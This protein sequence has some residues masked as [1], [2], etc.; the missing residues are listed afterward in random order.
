MTLK[1]D[2]HKLRFLG[3]NTSCTQEDREIGLKVA[4][5]KNVQDVYLAETQY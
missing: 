3:S 1:E 4:F 2:K 5:V